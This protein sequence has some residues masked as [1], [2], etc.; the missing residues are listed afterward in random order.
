M[1]Y[2]TGHFVLKH[3]Q[4]MSFCL[5]TRP[6]FTLIQACQYFPNLSFTILPTTLA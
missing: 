3:P 5:G 2:A 4:H 6:S 1:A